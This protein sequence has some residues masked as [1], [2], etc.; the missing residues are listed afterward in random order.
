MLQHVLCLDLVAFNAAETRAP[1]T[2][3]PW[4]STFPMRWTSSPGILLLLFLT[5]CWVGGVIPPPWPGNLCGQRLHWPRA[6]CLPYLLVDLYS[7]FPQVLQAEPLHVKHHQ[8][9]LNLPAQLHGTAQGYGS[10]NN[11]GPE[12][13]ARET[14]HCSHLPA[15]PAPNCPQGFPNRSSPPRV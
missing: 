14:L 3:T 8:H 9:R 2:P 4:P 10:H 7:R 15:S 13:P 1:A 5:G 11:S 12:V 6:S